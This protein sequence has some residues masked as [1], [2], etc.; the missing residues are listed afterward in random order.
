MVKLY[1]GNVEVLIEGGVTTFR[2]YVGGIVMQTLSAGGAPITKYLFHDHLGSLVRVAHPDGSVA[3][4]LDYAAFGQRRSY[5]DPHTA[6]TTPTTTPR[7]Y[8]G[9]EM[10]DGTGV[11]HMNGRIYDADLGRFL[12]PDPLIQAPDNAQSWNAYT[13]VF[14][15]PLRYTDPTGMLGQ[16]ERMWAATAIFIVGMIVAPQFTGPYAAAYAAGYAAAVGFAA[17]AVATKS[18]QGGLMGAFTSLVT[19]G[20][21]GPGGGFEAWAVRTFAGGVVGS[22]QGGNFGHAF[23]SAGLTAAFAPMV[24]R[25]S[26]DAARITVNALVGGTISEATGGKF[27]NGAVTGAIMAAMAGAAGNNIVGSDGSGAG[28]VVHPTADAFLQSESAKA[29]QIFPETYLTEDAA[30]SAAA[31]RYVGAGIASKREPGWN[32][33]QRGPNEFFFTYPYVGASKSPYGGTPGKIAAWDFGGDVGV[34]SV[35]WVGGGHGHWDS[36]SQFSGTDWLWLRRN[37]SGTLYLGAPNGSLYKSNW[38]HARQYG[39]GSTRSVPPSVFPG[40]PVEGASVKTTWP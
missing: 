21:G 30:N 23:V 20:L 33:Y 31:N 40:T 3:E 37:Q 6:G 12:Q 24:G 5:S 28:G 27:A 13:Y 34:R 19:A 25:I 38:R 1:L 4:G 9:H 8:T 2:R 7:G 14:N 32:V 16:E 35:Q 10:L 15:N 11:I 22:L 18:W 26:N 36:N 29:G 39:T 17:G